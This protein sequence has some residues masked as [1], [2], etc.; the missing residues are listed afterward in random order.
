MLFF[1]VN[2]IPTMYK[3]SVEKKELQD[4]A[5]YYEENI[6]KVQ[7]DIK[8]LRS[9]DKHLERFARENYSMHKEDEDVFIIVEEK[10][11]EK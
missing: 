3:L 11:K 5:K 10:V 8:Q 1:D 4:Q 2:D 7:E 6:E 9:D